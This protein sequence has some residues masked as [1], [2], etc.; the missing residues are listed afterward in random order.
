MIVYMSLVGNV[1][2]F[3]SR[4]DM[5]SVE[6]NQMNPLVEVNEDYVII[7]PTYSDT[8][9]DIMCDFIDYKDNR[10]YLKCVV[11]SGDKNFNRDYVFSAKNISKSYKI[12]LAFSFEKSGTDTDVE[13]FKKEVRKYWNHQN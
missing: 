9:T 1:R 6:I 10:K 12:P 5:D 3:V 4:L 7:M 13:N 2:N 8:L 11:G